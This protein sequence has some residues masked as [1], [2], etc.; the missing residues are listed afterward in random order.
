MTWLPGIY[1]SFL[2]W[3]NFWNLIFDTSPPSWNILR[4]ILGRPWYCNISILCHTIGMNPTHSGYKE[5]LMRNPIVRF[6]LLPSLVLH[7]LKAKTKT[8]GTIKENCMAYLTWDPNCNLCKLEKS[9]YI[10]QGFACLFIH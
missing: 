10:Y 3:I 7:V 6:F 8:R 5:N 1:L 2:I 9:W 4:A